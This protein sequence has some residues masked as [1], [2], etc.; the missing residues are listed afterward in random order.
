MND[1]TD[2]GKMT[3]ILTPRIK[4][5]QRSGD[6][7]SFVF[8]EFLRDGDGEDFFGGGFGDGEGADFVGEMG[9]GFLEVEG[10]GVVDLALYI[11]GLE[12]GGQNAPAAAAEGELVVDVA[13]IRFIV[14]EREVRRSY[15]AAV[16]VGSAA[17]DGVVV[18]E[19]RELD[20]EDGGLEF[21]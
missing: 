21:V 17:P 7:G 13:A 6:L 11:P 14:R 10:D 19:V 1:G 18:G 8:G 12:H 9:V 4:L 5:I 16:E 2:L 3:V 15:L 20:P